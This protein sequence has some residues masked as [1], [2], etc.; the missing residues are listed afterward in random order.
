M[1]DQ[2]PLKTFQE[3][4]NELHFLKSGSKKQFKKLKPSTINKSNQ[5]HFRDFQTANSDTNSVIL[6]KH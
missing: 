1:A 3:T 4:S 6:K 2:S 5:K